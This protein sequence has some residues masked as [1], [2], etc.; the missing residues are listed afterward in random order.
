MAA[1]ERLEAIPGELPDPTDPPRGCP[2]APRCPFVMEVCGDLD[3]AQFV[4]GTDRTA[5]CHLWAPQRTGEAA[6]P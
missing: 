4:V 6:T 3:P 1:D 2:F 5:A